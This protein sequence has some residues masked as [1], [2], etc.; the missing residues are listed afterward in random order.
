MPPSMVFSPEA[1]VASSCSDLR[2]ASPADETR[3]HDASRSSRRP[4][5]AV[6]P[7]TK[8]RAQRR[9]YADRVD[10]AR[11]GPSERD[12]RCGPSTLLRPGRN[13]AWAKARAHGH[14]HHRHQSLGTGRLPNHAA[15]RRRRDPLPTFICGSRR[16]ASQHLGVLVNVEVGLHDRLP[17]R[18]MY[19]NPNRPW[20]RACDSS[21]YESTWA[22]ARMTYVAASRAYVRRAGTSRD[23]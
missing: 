22:G 20:F 8:M 12:R 9:P 16:L 4:C 15:G 7:S 3:A 23:R 19:A 17:A 21:R 11:Q 1:P 13:D 2:R 14:G 5:R 18:A 6:V 10:P